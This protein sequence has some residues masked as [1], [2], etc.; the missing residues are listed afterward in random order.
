MTPL[1]VA[2]CATDLTA[3]VSAAT[4]SA[5]FIAQARFAA[6][7]GARIAVFAEYAAGG[8]LTLDN[9]WEAW[10]ATWRITALRAARETGIVICAGTWPVRDEGRLLN[11]ALIALPDGSSLHQDKLHPT[12]WERTWGIA[13]SDS[14]RVAEVAGARI[15]ILTCYDVEF[16]EACRAA[17]QAGAEVLLVPSWTDDRQGFHRVRLCAQARCIEDALYVVHAPLVGRLANVP[18]FEQA[19]GAAGILTP[20]DTGLAPDG[21]AAAGAWNQPE[22]VLADIDLERL[23]QVRAA[24]T[25]VPLAD[26][27]PAGAYRITR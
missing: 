26:A 18:G 23:R 12:P 22:V 8:L 16:P 20:C 21:V 17:A 15:A 4:W 10:E 3:A 1:R 27:R 9:R 6:D 11:R 24:G 13:P 5:A 2:A 14:L 25:V 19:I 7:G